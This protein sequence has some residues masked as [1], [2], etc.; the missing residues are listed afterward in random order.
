M[1]VIRRSTRGRPAP[2]SAGRSSRRWMPSRPARAPRTGDSSCD[3]PA[4][5][6]ARV[7]V[8]RPQP[9][10]QSVS[11]C[12]AGGRVH[13]ALGQD[14]SSSK[15]STTATT[16]GG[17]ASRRTKRA[18]GATCCAARES[19]CFSAGRLRCIAPH[20]HGFIRIHPDNPYAF[21]YADG[22][23]F[24]PMGDT[25]YGLYSDSPI[26]PA[27][28]TEYLKTRRSQRFNFV[29]MGVVHSPTHG[30]T[31]PDFW[32]WGGTPGEARPRPLQPAVLSR[33][34]RPAGRDAAVGDERR[35]D[36]AQLLPAAVHRCEGLDAGS[37]SGC[38]CATSSPAMRPSQPLPLDHRQRIRDAPRRPVPP[39]RA[40]TIRTGPRRRP[41]SSS[42]T[43]PIGTR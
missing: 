28:R 27:L 16:P 41:G 11:R 36:P 29:R 39:R 20:G 4:L 33:P 9:C 42:S 22:T 25:C 18:N 32:P 26:T 37:G 8:A 7:R 17:C 35:V 2:I 3:C 10:G 31:D 24:F 34:R 14:R 43:T 21:A 30:Q 12:G 38:G 6:D 15:D 1:T 5:G 23:P 13:L 40:R 19:S